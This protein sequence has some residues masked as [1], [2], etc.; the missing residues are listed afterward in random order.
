MQEVSAMRCLVTVT[1]D[2]CLLSRALSLIAYNAD[3]GMKKA[4][5]GFY[6][7]YVKVSLCSNNQVE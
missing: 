2:T 5:G 1:L 7:D 3:S 6:D 4:Q